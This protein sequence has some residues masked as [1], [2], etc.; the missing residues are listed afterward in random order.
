VFIRSIADD[1]PFLS[2]KYRLKRNFL[3]P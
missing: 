2:N 1:I 3:A